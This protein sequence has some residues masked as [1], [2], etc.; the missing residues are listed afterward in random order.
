MQC[1][2]LDH[3]EPVRWQY[4]LYKAVADVTRG[5]AREWDERFA[6]SKSFEKTRTKRKFKSKH[7]TPSDNVHVPVGVANMQA[8]VLGSNRGSQ[9][10][11]C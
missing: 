5:V 2:K 8:R 7:C 1:N 9:E 4:V 10:S 3:T 11:S 6:G